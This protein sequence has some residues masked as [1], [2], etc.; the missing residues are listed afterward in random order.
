MQGIDEPTEPHFGRPRFPIRDGIF[1]A[2]FK[3]YS[4]LSG[5]RFTSDLCD[6][7]DKGYLTK[8]PHFNSV[9]NVF[10]CEGT[11]EI[12]K[13]LVA[14]SAAPLASLESNVAIDS[15]GFSGCRYDRW[16]ECKWKNAP[17]ITKRSWVWSDDAPDGND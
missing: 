3:V 8:V 9:L 13:S 17:P 5:R 14:H 16:F 10:D 12:L 1:S 6:A 7:Q 11:T 15:T 2:V 4:M